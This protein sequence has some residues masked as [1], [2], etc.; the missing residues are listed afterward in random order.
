[1]GASA[2]AMFAEADPQLLLEAA[3]GHPFIQALCDAA[4]DAV[5]IDHL[6]AVLFPAGL[7]ATE[8]IEERDAAR[9]DFLINLIAALSHIRKVA[10]REAASVDLH[11]W[12]RALSR[13]DRYAGPSAGYD[14][15]DDGGVEEH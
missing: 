1:E 8:T 4:T 2:Q 6:A 5:S 3:Q 14:W 9:T 10:G 13:L 15:T 12:V 11:L 7:A